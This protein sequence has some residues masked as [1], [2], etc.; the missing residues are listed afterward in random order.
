MCCVTD[1]KLTLVLSGRSGSNRVYSGHRED[2]SQSSQF[3]CTVC[4]ITFGTCP[5]VTCG[6]MIYFLSAHRHLHQLF[7]LVS[8]HAVFSLQLP[9]EASSP[10]WMGQSPVRVGPESTLQTRTASG[11][12]LP[13]RSTA[14]LCS[15]TSLR[16]R[17]MTWALG[18]LWI[19]TGWVCS[20][21]SFSLSLH[22]ISPLSQQIKPSSLL[23]FIIKTK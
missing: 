3:N 18:L 13:P 8:F 21:F 23:C 12:W 9:V 1:T 15:L 16:L 22:Y 14:S 11:S 10:S 7:V 2:I 19:G 17:A 5:V 4:N 20:V 6:D